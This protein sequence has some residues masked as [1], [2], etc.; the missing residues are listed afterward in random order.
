[1]TTTTREQALTPAE[2]R[3]LCAQLS[4][5]GQAMLHRAVHASHMSGL[6]LGREQGLREA[7]EVCEAIDP[8][9]SSNPAMLCA[10]NIEQ[11]R[12]NP[13]GKGR[14]LVDVPLTNVLGLAATHPGR[15]A[16]HEAGAKGPG[17]LTT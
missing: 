9:A 3:E 14:P 5:D 10:M 16:P 8:R 2:L 12:A 13:S 11:L 1:M 15:S 17:A 7:K 4:E 6:E